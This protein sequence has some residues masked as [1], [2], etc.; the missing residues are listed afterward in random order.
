MPANTG[1]AAII[2]ATAR[3]RR[4]TTHKMKRGA[5]TA[6]HFFLFAVVASEATLTERMFSSDAHRKSG[7][8]SALVQL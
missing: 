8:F 2:T 5:L 3:Q 4:I 7:V 1:R 6:P